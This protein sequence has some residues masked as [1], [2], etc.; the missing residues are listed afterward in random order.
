MRAGVRLSVWAGVLCLVLSACGTDMKQLLREDTEMTW[1]TMA[2]DD[3]MDEA[4]IDPDAEFLD[5][6]NEK[7]RACQEVYEHVQRRV[8]YA[9]QHGDAPFFIQMGRDLGRLI[10]RLVPIGAIEDC[11]AAFDRYRAAMARMEKQVPGQL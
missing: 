10:A 8:L 7:Q 6:E 5:A 11:A 1:K 3:A 9:A 4:G 2:L